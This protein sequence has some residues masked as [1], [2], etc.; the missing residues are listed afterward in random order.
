MPLEETGME[1]FT[2]TL[3]RQILDILEEIKPDII[4]TGNWIPDAGKIVTTVV[5]KKKAI[6]KYPYY[7]YHPTRYKDI[8]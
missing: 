6:L 5:I 4:L 8:G 3:C 1:V 7:M 2:R